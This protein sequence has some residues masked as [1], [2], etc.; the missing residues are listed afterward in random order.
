MIKIIVVGDASV[1]KTS[2]VRRFCN[3]EFSQS[4]RSTVA[5]DFNNKLYETKDKQTLK[6]QLWDIPGQDKFKSITKLYVKGA[7]GAVIVC[8]ITNEESINSCKTWKQILEENCDE[9]DGEII[10]M[11]MFQ[12]KIDLLE[13]FGNL[14]SYMEESFAKE[15]AT[16]NKFTVAE[17]GSA[18]S[19]ENINESFEKLLET[20]AARGLNNK[21]VNSG[22][23]INLDNRN[24][25]LGKADKG[26]SC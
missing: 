15:L 8:D 11:M 12:N 13:K 18:L 17:R 19:G 5:C 20:I 21:V 16:E 23:K 3:N 2:L 26:C 10:P 14:E 22:Q 24:Q 6:V 1:G 4:E 7:V 9:Y 25:N